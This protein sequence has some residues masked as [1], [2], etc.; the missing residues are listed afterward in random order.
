MLKPVQTA[1]L[2]CL[3]LAMDRRG[4]N[5]RRDLLTIAEEFSQFVLEGK[6]PSADPAKD[7]AG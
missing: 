6:T 2:E 3:K 7:P 5:D 4:A 1:R